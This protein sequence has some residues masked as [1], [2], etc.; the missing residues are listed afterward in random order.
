MQNQYCVEEAF[1]A[2]WRPTTKEDGN[3]LGQ[4][5]VE[6]WK[7]KCIVVILGLDHL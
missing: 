1:Q 4:G 2:A 3:Q 5:M 6:E 7:Q